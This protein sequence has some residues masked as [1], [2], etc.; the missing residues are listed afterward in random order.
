M[1]SAQHRTP[2]QKNIKRKEL[3]MDIIDFELSPELKDLKALTAE[4]TKKEIYPLVAG[5][6]LEGKHVPNELYHKMGEIGL[7]SLAIPEEYGGMGMGYLA[8]AIAT[9]EICRYAHAAIGSNLIS[10]FNG[11]FSAPIIHY[12]TKEQ[13]DEILPRVIAG[14]LK[15]AMCITEPG[16]SALG[17]LNTKATPDG[18]NYIVNGQKIFITRAEDCEKHVVIAQEPEG[19][20]ALLIDACTPGVTVGK[21]EG[22]MGLRGIGL[23]PVSYDNVVVPKKNIIGK[24]G[25]GLKIA[26]DSLYEAR[27]SVAACSV[28]CAQGAIDLAVEYA[29]TRMI[30]KHSLA[31]FQN[32]QFVLA[33]AQS[34]VDAARL[35]VWRCGCSLN[36]GENEAYVS[37][38]AKS[39]ASEICTEVVDKCLQVFGGYGYCEGFDIERLYRDVRV[40]RIMDGS[41]EIHKRLISKVMGVR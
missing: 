41:T 12:G 9:E 26:S 25:Q 4:F 19:A 34:K 38:M 10:G 32:T 28:G 20:I 23:C 3:N 36:R 33:D 8:T 6:D 40:L 37:S 1:R 24:V 18:D 13:Q 2:P 16:A 5:W 11:S 35:L 29:K 17:E 22:K 14:N 27:M 30:G 31:S 39:Y 21:S 7:L 15:L